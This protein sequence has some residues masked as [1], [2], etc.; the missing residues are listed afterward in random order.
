MLNHKAQLNILSHGVCVIL[1]KCK[2]SSEVLILGSRMNTR[3]AIA[4]RA[5]RLTLPDADI[6]YTGTQHAYAGYAY[7]DST[8]GQTALYRVGTTSIPLVNVNNGCST[9]PSEFFVA[10]QAVEHGVVLGLRTSTEPR[11]DGV[12]GERNA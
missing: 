3:D 10:H 7:D 4:E 12:A 2:V 6:S 9:G 5:V 11:S 8:S 1:P